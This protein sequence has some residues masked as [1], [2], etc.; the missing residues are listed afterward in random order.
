MKHPEGEEK[1]VDIKKRTSTLP[2]RSEIHRQKKKKT[3]FKIKYPIIR[4]LALLFILLPVAILSFKFNTNPEKLEASP[5]KKSANFESISYENKDEAVRYP[6]T[7]EEET[8]TEETETERVP[9]T[10]EQEETKQPEVKKQEEPKEEAGQQ[11]NENTS[12]NEEAKQPVQEQPK[13]RYD[14]KYHK[15]K[16]DETLYRI[17]MKYYKSRSGEELIKR[18]NNLNGDTVIEGQVLKIPIKN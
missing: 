6:E 13:D 5:V 7:D 14:V 9:E 11:V 1:S 3:R 16:A 15:V 4:L 12:S 18:E 2:S 17:S 8:P 10:T